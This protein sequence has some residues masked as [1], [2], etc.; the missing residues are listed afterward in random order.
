LPT[1]TNHM[2]P[3]KF[4]SIQLLYMQL[5]KESYQLQYKLP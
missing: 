2:Q 5:K 3:N 1:I 4:P